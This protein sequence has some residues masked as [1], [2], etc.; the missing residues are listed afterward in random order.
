[1]QEPT[2]GRIV[3]YF[4]SETGSVRAAIIVKVNDDDTVNLAAWTRD[5]VQL[6]VVGVKQGSEYGQW[7]WPPRV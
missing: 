1:M 7:N 6:P 5:G 4:M 2:I 3:H